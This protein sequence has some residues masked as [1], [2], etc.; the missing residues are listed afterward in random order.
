MIAWAKV[1]FGCFRTGLITCASRSIG[2]NEKF[3]N[4]SREIREEVSTLSAGLRFQVPSWNQIGTFCQI[5]KTILTWTLAHSISISATISPNNGR[6]SFFAA[7]QTRQ[8]LSNSKFFAGIK[9]IS[10]IIF[11]WAVHRPRN[12]RQTNVFAVRMLFINN[13]NCS[14]NRRFPTESNTNRSTFSPRTRRPAK[15][16]YTTHNK[17]KKFAQIPQDFHVNVENDGFNAF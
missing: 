16:K 11:N 14:N 12:Q 4:L 3:K 8:I 9:S 2:K 10:S 5:P 17:W 1:H 6:I 13:L 7:K 15:E